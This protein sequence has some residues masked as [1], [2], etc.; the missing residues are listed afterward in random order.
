[1]HRYVSLLTRRWKSL[2]L[3]LSAA[4]AV[5]ALAAPSASAYIYLAGPLDG[6]R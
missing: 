4:I 2:L 6:G 3:V 5:L 1:M